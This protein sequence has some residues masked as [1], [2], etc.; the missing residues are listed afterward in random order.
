MEILYRSCRHLVS[1]C[2]DFDLGNE[3]LTIIRRFAPVQ[4]DIRWSIVAGTPHRLN[5][6]SPR[7]LRPDVPFQIR[8]HVEDIWGNVTQN[9]EQH[10]LHLTIRNGSTSILTQEIALPAKGWSNVNHDPVKPHEAGQYD[11]VAEL[12][13]ADGITILSKTSPLTID[14]SLSVPRTLFGDLH[15]HSDDTVGTE[16]STYNFTYGRDIAGLDLPG[17]TANDFQISQ[18]RWNATVDL[19]QELNE[20]DSF[21]IYP[22][23]EWCGNSAAGGDHNVV[24]L[25]DSP[26]EAIEF[27]FDRHGNV[28]RSFE[29]SED[30]PK[31]L[32]PGA[33]P[34]D[35]VYATYAADPENH[36]MIPHVGGRRC[37]SPGTILASS[38]SSR[39]A[40]HGASSSGRSKTPSGAAGRW[41]SAPTRTSTAAG[42]AA[43]SPAP[44][45]LAPAAA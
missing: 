33:W 40:A 7:L 42:A 12:K 8:T 26:K 34:L 35:E 31:D 5:I 3:R 15:V 14:E 13:N 25:A 27:P 4:P 20:P 37:T 6:V 38:A 32:V 17:Y 23:T 39:L 16:D 30:G 28:A 10:S 1:F 21:V 2:Q 29:W 11:V 9:I 22:G 43:A 44:P 41:A 18:A 36:L 24:F 19:I 45:S